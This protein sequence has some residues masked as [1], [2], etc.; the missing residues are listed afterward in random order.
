VQEAVE[1]VAELTLLAIRD[2]T[3]A[4]KRNLESRANRRQA[5]RKQK[6]AN[7]KKVELDAERQRNVGSSKDSEAPK[8]CEKCEKLEEDIASLEGERKVSAKKSGEKAK[9]GLEAR[10]GSQQRRSEASDVVATAR[11]A[12]SSCMKKARET[13]QKYRSRSSS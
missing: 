3:K 5:H 12:A 2:A 11:S 8:R 4:C 6:E 10:R 13:L 9:G 1:K 7:E